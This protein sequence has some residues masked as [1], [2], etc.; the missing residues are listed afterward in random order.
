MQLTGVPGANQ[1]R[2][3][4]IESVCK[5]LRCPGGEQLQL[6][7]VRRLELGV[8]VHLKPDMEE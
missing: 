6:L 7:A 4:L 8:C 3:G 2:A 5:Q 1:I